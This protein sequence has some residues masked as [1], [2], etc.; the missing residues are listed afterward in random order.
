MDWVWSLHR[1]QRILEAIDER[2]G[3]DY[4]PEEAKRLL[5]LGLACSHPIAFERPQMAVIL[6]I[7]SG[8]TVAPAIPPF[9]PAFVWPSGYGKTEDGDTTTTTMS[10]RFMLQPMTRESYAGSSGISHM[11]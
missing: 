4:V 10:S 3:D 6:Q 7:M 9:R 5:L 1:E 8:L 11:C 2:L